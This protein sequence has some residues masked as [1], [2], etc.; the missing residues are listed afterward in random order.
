MTGTRSTNP[1]SV[2]LVSDSGLQTNAIRYF[3]K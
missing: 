3:R 1:T 2:G